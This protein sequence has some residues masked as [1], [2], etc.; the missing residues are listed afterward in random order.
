M[1][2]AILIESGDMQIGVQHFYVRISENVCGGDLV[3]SLNLDGNYSGFIAM[4][5]EQEFLEIEDDICYVL[6]NPRDCGKFVID[7]FDLHRGYG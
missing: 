3:L 1:E 5:L 7:S 4:H 6:S 2:F